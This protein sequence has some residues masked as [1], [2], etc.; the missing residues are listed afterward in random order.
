MVLTNLGTRTPVFGLGWYS[1][2]PITLARNRRYICEVSM[3]TADEDLIYSRFIFRYIYRTR[4]TPVAVSPTVAELFFDSTVQF[5]PFIVW[6]N[7]ANNREATFQVRRIPI[8]S[9]P[10]TLQDVD[11]TLNLDPDNAFAP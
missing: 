6:R 10:S 9:D 2:E 3:V 7:L 11:I 1:F 8:Y 5:F 4:D